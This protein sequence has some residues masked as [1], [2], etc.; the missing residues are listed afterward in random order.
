MDLRVWDD[1]ESEGRTVMVRIG[2]DHSTLA[3]GQWADFHRVSRH[4][5][6]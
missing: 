1:G 5:R 2:V 4:E 6:V 3:A